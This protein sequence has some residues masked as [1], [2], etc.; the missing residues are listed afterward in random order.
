MQDAEEPIE[1]RT[2]AL[3]RRVRRRG[4]VRRGAL[5][6]L[7]ISGWMAYAAV[8]VA[9]LVLDER[10][11]RAEL[12]RLDEPMDRLLAVEER[13]ASFSP[14]AEAL[15]RQADPRAHLTP[16]LA[17]VAT[18]LPQDT[19]LHGIEIGRSEALELQAHGPDPVYVVRVMGDWWPGAV[20]LADVADADDGPAYT[21]TV[22]LERS[23]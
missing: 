15:A 20:R 21:F 5:V 7:A 9:D 14:L 2:P 12:S 16:L 22:V 17:Q 11:V 19:H 4:W 8:Y 10:W 6:A 13:I 1:L 18:T 3:D 23:S